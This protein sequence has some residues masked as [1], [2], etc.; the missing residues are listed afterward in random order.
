[1][2]R[3]EQRRQYAIE[4]AKRR[5]RR[6][7]VYAVVYRPEGKPYYLVNTGPSLKEAMTVNG[8]Y[9]Y[10]VPP[11]PRREDD[12]G[13]HP[14]SQQPSDGTEAAP[15]ATEDQRCP[16]CGG[17]KGAPNPVDHRGAC[18]K[19]RRRAEAPSR[20]SRAGETS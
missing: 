18:H 2:N 6:D 17:D 11:I 20:K 14:A 16:Y 15:I 9:V 13:P 12:G 19:T 1:M 8:A 5:S 7:G 4:E 3:D 10:S